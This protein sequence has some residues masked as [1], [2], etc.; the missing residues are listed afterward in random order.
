[1]T[2]QPV[3]ECR[4][5]GRDDLTPQGHKS[6]ETY[7]DENPNRGIPYDKQDELDLLESKEEAVEP[8]HPNPDQS[9]SDESGSG[10]PSVEKLSGSKSTRAAATDGGS[11]SCPVCG[12]EEVTAAKEA[13]EDYI[14]AVEHPNPKAVLAYELAESACREPECSALWGPKYDEPLTMREVVNA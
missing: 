9:V 7:C 1:M 10:L 8:D 5:C 11:E 6:H 14:G 4:F 13:K 12:T 3:M 2:G